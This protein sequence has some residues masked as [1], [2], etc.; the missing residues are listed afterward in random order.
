MK[1]MDPQ[2]P[3][4]KPGRPLLTVSLNEVGHGAVFLDDEEISRAC[5]AVRIESRVGE[6]TKATIEVIAPRIEFQG[7]AEVELVD[8]TTMPTED[9]PTGPS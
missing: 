5:C 1:E 9:R 2:E 4:S 3:R 7:E 6:A 8:V